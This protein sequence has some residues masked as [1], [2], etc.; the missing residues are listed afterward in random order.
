MLQ[1]LLSNALKY[2][3]GGG[4]IDVQLWRE[5]RD[6]SDWAMLAVRDHGLG[7]PASDLGRIFERF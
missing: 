7:I 5:Q 1:N 4:D 6:A 2:S 3:P